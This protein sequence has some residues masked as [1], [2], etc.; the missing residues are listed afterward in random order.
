MFC[1]ICKSLGFGDFEFLRH[2]ANFKKFCQFCEILRL[3]QCTH[4]N[5]LLHL[6]LFFFLMS[7]TLPEEDL[8]NEAVAAPDDDAADAPT[9]KEPA[10]NRAATAPQAR[11][12]Q[13]K[14]GRFC[15]CGKTMRCNSVFH[16]ALQ[17]FVKCC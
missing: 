17:S 9:K 3:R 6:R 5:P 14:H 7:E 10:V 8:V 4:N 13:F 11:A 15:V 1:V 12:R 2:F 16:S